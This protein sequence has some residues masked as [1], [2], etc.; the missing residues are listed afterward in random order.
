MKKILCPTDFSETAN[1]AIVYGAKLAQ[2]T[3]ASLTLLNVQSLFDFAPVEIVEGKQATVNRAIQNLEAQSLEISNAFKI[4]C[5]V[6]V[7]SRYQKLSTIID[8]K[9]A[10]FDLILMGTNGSDDIYQFFTGSNTYNVIVKTKTPLL[11]IPNDCVYSEIK[12]VIYA[13]DYLR[14]GHLPVG[15]LRPFIKELNCNLKVLQVMEEAHSQDV[16]QELKDMQFILKDLYMDLS[17]EFDTI[18]SA[19]I[20][21]SINNYMLHNQADVLALCSTHRNIVGRLFH[22]SVIQ[23]ISS[24]CTYPLYIFHH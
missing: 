8:E 13:F 21:R 4:S 23:N 7:E 20:P 10:S 15:G 22:K 14:E 24:F 5:Y 12:S 19:E 3:H 17:Y 1:N 16:D 2:A 6:E 9:A 11:L 18:R